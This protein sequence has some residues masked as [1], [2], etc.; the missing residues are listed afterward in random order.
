MSERAPA[1]NAR[2]RRQR[3]YRL[4]GIVLHRRDQGEADRLITLLTPNQGRVTL[5]A[6]GAR[7]ITSRKAGHLELFTHVRVQVAQA[8]TW[9]IITQAE[10][11][12]SYPRL[13]ASLPRM[14]H[15][16][17][18]AELLLHFAPE[19]EADTPLFDLAL[20]TLAYLNGSDN[21]LLVSRWFEAH[22]LRITGFQPQLYVCTGCRAPLSLDVTNYWVP[23]E[24]GV[25]CPRCGEAKRHAMPLPPRLL[26]LMRYLQVHTLA[27]ARTL[28]VTPETWRELE[29]YVQGYLR[30]ILERDIHALAFIRR[31][32]Q[33]KG[34]G[35]REGKGIGQ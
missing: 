22:L 35:G 21:L 16:Y 13:R 28:P 27:E 12:H 3:S 31:L 7:K 18:M 11:L 25:Q 20:E 23:V 6:K 10:T 33:E 26:K 9:H 8:R 24:G 30:V 19:G 15:A 32:R 4:T 14:A 1:T 17:Y 2:T 5:I 34:K 29:A